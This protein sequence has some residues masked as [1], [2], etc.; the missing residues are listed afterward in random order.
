MTLLQMI[1]NYQNNN[2]LDSL[3]DILEYL[4]NNPVYIIT[5]I[6]ISKKRLLTLPKDEIKFLLE[7]PV[8]IDN[9]LYF[10]IFSKKVSKYC[11]ELKLIDYLKLMKKLNVNTIVIDYNLESRLFLLKD[12]I[13]YLKYIVAF[14]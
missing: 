12:T 9:K 2:D 11:L 13:E 4:K 10:S 1:Y 14:K 7:N 5:K 6:K 8:S 3:R